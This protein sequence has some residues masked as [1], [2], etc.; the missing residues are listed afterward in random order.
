MDQPAGTHCKFLSSQSSA[1]RAGPRK[2]LNACA[3]GIS[4]E[5]RRDT[6]LT[7]FSWDHKLRLALEFPRVLKLGATFAGWRPCCLRLSGQW[8]SPHSSM[9]SPWLAV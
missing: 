7:T 2:N 1:C 5:Y 8:E 6:Y 3:K 4:L 9:P